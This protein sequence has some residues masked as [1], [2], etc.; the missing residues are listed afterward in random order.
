M[1]NRN[2][3]NGKIYCI[4]NYVDDDIYVGR[5]TQPLSKRMEKHR[6]DFKKKNMCLP[7]LHEKIHKH[8]IDNFYIEL[9]EK[10]PCENIEELRAK[11]GEWIRKMGTLNKCVAGRTQ[12]QYREDNAEQIKEKKHNHYVNNKELYKVKN[13]NYYYNNK[14]QI[15]IQHQE[16]YQK[17]KEEYYERNIKYKE[18]NPEKVKAYQKDYVENNYDKIKAYQ[19][20]YRQENKEALNKW[21]TTKVICECGGKY[22]LSHK[23]EH[24]KSKKHQNYLNNNISN[25]PST[26]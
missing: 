12:Q 16:Y 21:K 6:S 10:T 5:T 4:R 11:E 3:K 13:Q 8:G 7:K 19:E 1:D 14:E 26:Q 2:Y 23:A 24:L 25:V 17:H 22:T 18:N 20:T 15:D 9:L